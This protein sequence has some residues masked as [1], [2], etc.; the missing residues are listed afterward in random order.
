MILSNHTG[1]CR[2]F[3]GIFLINFEVTIVSTAAVSI[4]NELDDY[5]ASS[6]LINAY[7][8]T[9]IGKSPSSY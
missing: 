6:W 1:T 8:I 4:T 7:L 5:A 3:L 9:Y 2:L